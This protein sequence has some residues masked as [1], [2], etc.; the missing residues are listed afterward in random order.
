LELNL[1]RKTYFLFIILSSALLISCAGGGGGGGGSST[2]SSYGN[3]S[4]TYSC[5][6]TSNS[7]GSS[8]ASGTSS[9]YNSSTASTWASNQE[10]DNVLYNGAVSG[11]QSTQNPYEVMNVHKAYAYDLSGDDITIHVQ[12]SGFDKDHHEFNGKDVSLYQN[13]YTSDTTSSYHANSVASV[14]LGDYNGISSGDINSSTGSMMGV[15]YNADLYFSDYDTLKSGSDYASDW[16]DALDGA[17]SATAASNHSYGITADI[18]TVK[19]YQSSNG[20]SDAA[21]I[22][23]YMDAAGLSSTTSGASDFI[24]SLKSFQ[25]NKGVIVWALGNHSD[26]SW[27]TD[28]VH[29]L[30]AL[31]ELDSDLKGAWITAATV[32]IEGSAGNETYHNRYQNC[33]ITASYCLATDSYGIAVAAYENMNSGSVD[34]NNSS[35]YYAPTTGNSFSAPMISG[36]VA[37][38]SE[39]FP[40]LT[41]KEI[42]SRLFATADNTF[43]THDAYTTFS[44]GIKH[45]F[46]FRYGHGIPDLYKALQPI[47]SSMM[48]NT[49][50]I[51]GNIDTSAHH[52]LDST[53]LSIGSAFGDS[54]DL[55]LSGE[56]GYFHD[57]LYGYFP[58][59]AS[60][61]VNSIKK[62]NFNN[63]IQIKEIKSS[64][65][66]K[67]SYSILSFT[68]SKSSD[69]IDT[70]TFK[71]ATFFSSSGDH[72]FFS[73]FYNPLEISM[74]FIPLNNSNANFVYK[75]GFG[76]PFIKDA[77][78]GL[79]FGSNYNIS[80]IS[81]FSIGMFQNENKYEK[82]NNGISVSYN[83]N[84]D[85]SYSSLM[86]GFKNEEESFLSS[87]GS[88][89]Y[90]LS[91]AV[92]P[93]TFLGLSH[94]KS[95]SDKID[96]I[97]NGSLGYTETNIPDQRLYENVSP[98]ISSSF[99]TAL[100]VKNFS[101]DKDNLILSV[102]QPHRV[103]SGSAHLIIPGHRDRNGDLSSKSKE[104]S[105]SP[106]GREID[107]GI[108]YN[109][110]LT[111]STLISMVGNIKNN[112]DHIA[113]NDINNSLSWSVNYNF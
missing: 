50:L 102:S 75:D 37:L 110:K 64:E 53:N 47:T 98:I 92:S 82:I 65:D 97:F 20:L 61:Q 59:E 62:E 56:V 43:F 55:A 103:E 45:G 95:I 41:P 72:K 5:S 87:G 96:I 24:S 73:S 17:P 7:N 25:T 52:S 46:N 85:N 28:K 105:L 29:F 66:D 58:Y 81:N 39:A 21:T 9:S 104:F 13:N 112:A 93:T 94:S 10:F 34:T 18:E 27:N 111:A 26:Q 33:G 80:D 113:T 42:A 30:A 54:F 91:D 107:I 71:G 70:E 60:A 11:V 79:A 57:A 32:D 6:N 106:S 23:A 1:K 44:G 36:S 67:N 69:K 31:P 12:D 74:G 77:M 35:S 109:I 14:A 38:L 78:N 22:E 51:G 19:A 83:L 49:L 3:S 84:K 48:G 86:F 2:S 108:T 90:D 89:A 16:S 76:I 68:S 40:S 8:F 101:S 63:Q 15:A 99:G 4:C 88:G 100:T